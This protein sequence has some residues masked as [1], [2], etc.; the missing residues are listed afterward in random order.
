[1]IYIGKIKSTKHKIFQQLFNKEKAYL[2][3]R[4]LTVESRLKRLEE[5]VAPKNAITY[6][7]EKSYQN[8][9]CSLCDI[10]ISNNEQEMMS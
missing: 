9:L 4:I 1:M 6:Y 2:M 3:G 7:T 8:M 10:I 5:S